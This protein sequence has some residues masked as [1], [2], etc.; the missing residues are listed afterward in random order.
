MALI[1]VA[2]PVSTALLLPPVLG[3]CTTSLPTY[4]SMHTISGRFQSVVTYDLSILDC[5]FACVI[6][7]EIESLNQFHFS[8]TELRD[9]V[10]QMLADPAVVAAVQ[11]NWS[12]DF[13]SSFKY[14][15]CYTQCPLSQLSTWLIFP[16]PSLPPPPPPPPP[17]PTTHRHTCRPLTRLYINEAD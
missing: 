5:V 8:H 10:S 15:C 9:L 4:K 12:C 3:M 17:H 2:G 13:W 1:T 11:V 16:P 6:V 7:P 14:C